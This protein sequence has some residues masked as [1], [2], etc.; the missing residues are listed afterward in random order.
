MGER[1][2]RCHGREKKIVRE[3]ERLLERERLRERNKREKG[4]ERGRDNLLLG[5]INALHKYSP[6][7]KGI[8]NRN[9]I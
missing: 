7:N 4:R 6:I 2:R 8:L 3:R 1:E 9:F 5:N